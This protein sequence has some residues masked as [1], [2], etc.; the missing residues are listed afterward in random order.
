MAMRFRL[1][2]PAF[3][4]GLAAASVGLG[5]PA[6]QAA[7]ANVTLTTFAGY[8]VPTAPA[9]ATA[10]MG[11]KVPT[12]SG[13]TSAK[14]GVAIGAGVTAGTGGTLSVTGAAVVIGCTSGKASYGGVLEIKN[15]VTTL[16]VTVSPGDSI[17]LSAS[18]SATK[19]TV[20]FADSTKHFSKS[21]TGTGVTPSQ[22]ADGMTAVP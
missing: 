21:L 22:V 5:A 8:G 12:V 16:T 15:K 1:S 4:V 18:L 6:A 17:L 2:V 11:F 20:S 3:A 19:A 10:S 14:S 7:P 13:C 9:T